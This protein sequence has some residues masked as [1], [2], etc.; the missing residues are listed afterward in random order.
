MR[1]YAAWLCRFVSCDPLQFEYPHYTPYQ[2]AGNKPIT[3]IDLDGAEEYNPDDFFGTPEKPIELDTLV[4]EGER[5][6]IASMDAIKSQVQ[7]PPDSITLKLFPILTTEEA[8]RMA[9]HVYGDKTD[10]I[11]TGGWRVSDR[12][13][14]GVKYDNEDTGLKS[15]LYERVVDGNVTEYAYVTAGT[16]DGK[17]WKFGNLTQPFGFSKQ[18]KQASKNAEKISNALGFN[19]LTFIGHSLGGGLA[20]LNALSTNRSAITFNPAGV[21]EITKLVDGGLKAYFRREKTRIDAYV[22]ITDP[23]YTLQNKLLKGIIPDVNGKMHKLFPTDFPSVY[24]GH[25]IDNILKNF[26]IRNPQKYNKPK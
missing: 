7:L 15:M 16:E 2:Y 3:Y 4:V 13:F 19:V 8:V 20:A 10:D 21:S 22:M 17:D 18:Y 12:K 1:Y 11:L 5:K 9:A 26:G 6:F 14:E 23:L 24:N 25:S